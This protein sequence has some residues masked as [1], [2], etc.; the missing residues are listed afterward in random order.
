ME[1]RYK[2]V[3]CHYTRTLLGRLFQFEHPQLKE[4]LKSSRGEL[5]KASL[6]IFATILDWIRF[7][8]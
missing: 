1:D 5:D 4:R 8:E 6:S 7:H 2:L 3:F